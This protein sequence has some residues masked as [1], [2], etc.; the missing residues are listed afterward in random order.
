M[1][2]VPIGPINHSFNK[3]I[4]DFEKTRSSD[5]KKN[6]SFSKILGNLVDQVNSLQNK[7]DGSIQNLIS[8][9][10]E[11]IHQVMIAVEEADL[12]FRLMM[13]IRNKLTEAYQ[14]IVR[15]QI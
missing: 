8:G 1:K 6:S 13:E 14:E 10:T 7:A 4:Q 5:D 12:A 15:M 11:S 2:N 9:E 3:L